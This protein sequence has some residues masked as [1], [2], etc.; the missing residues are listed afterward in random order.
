M[1]AAHQTL[2]MRGYVFHRIKIIRGECHIHNSISWSPLID[3][4]AKFRECTYLI[5]KRRPNTDGNRASF[6][7]RHDGPVC[8]RNFETILS[9]ILFAIL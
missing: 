2:A 5:R 7:Q 4:N 9:I 6:A 3:L 1:K 8:T